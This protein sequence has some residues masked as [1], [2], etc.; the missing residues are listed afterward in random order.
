M[1]QF[2]NYVLF[3]IEPTI[4]LVFIKFVTRYYIYFYHLPLRN[5]KGSYDLVVVH[6]SV[7]L[8]VCLLVL[9]ENI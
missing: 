6:L 4:Y 1:L 9:Y 8:F 2:D 7:C 3:Y 5:D